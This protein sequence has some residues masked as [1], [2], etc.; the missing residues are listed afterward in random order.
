MNFERPKCECVDVGARNTD[1]VAFSMVMH[2]SYRTSRKPSSELRA[3]T[4]F[5]S[6]FREACT[7][8]AVFS[9]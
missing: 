1:L 7:E 5:E 6:K 3:A 4:L 8:S 2:C 9:A